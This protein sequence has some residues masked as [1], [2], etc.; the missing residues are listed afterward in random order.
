MGSIPK[1][2]KNLYNINVLNAMLVALY[3]GI[4]QMH[5]G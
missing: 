3:K 2:T 4:C 5:K 1:E